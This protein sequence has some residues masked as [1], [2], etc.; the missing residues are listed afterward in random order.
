MNTMTLEYLL[1]NKCHIKRGDSGE[2]IQMTYSSD[3]EVTDGSRVP[4]T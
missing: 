1:A 3:R 2:T 4:L